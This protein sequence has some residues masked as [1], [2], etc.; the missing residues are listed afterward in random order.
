[1]ASQRAVVIEPVVENLL[2]VDR[3]ARRLAIGTISS[4]R[5]EGR[6]AGKQ[7][8]VAGQGGDHGITK[9]IWCV[10]VARRLEG[11]RRGI[12]DL[13]RL[14]SPLPPATRTLP[15]FGPLVSSVAVC[16]K[17]AS[18]IAPVA[19]NLPVAGL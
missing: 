15:E 18:A 3:K 5:V 10:G 19:V 4:Q 16:R 1:M 6:A 14:R 11:L 9:M 2:V 8:I 7:D 17:R 13:G 12:V